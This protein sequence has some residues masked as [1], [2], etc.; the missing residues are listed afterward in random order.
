MMALFRW[1]IS[2]IVAVASVLF[3]LGNRDMIALRWSP[4]HDT[5]A[6]PVFAPVLLALLAG[7]LLGGLF[8]WLNALP[9]RVERRRQRKQIDRLQDR[10]RD[11][12]DR[13][14]QSEQGAPAT[15]PALLPSP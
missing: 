3:A 4:L 15:P 8:V 5:V 12:E 14:S 10:L 11:A 7:F 2:I 6:L 1:T 13:A 9:V